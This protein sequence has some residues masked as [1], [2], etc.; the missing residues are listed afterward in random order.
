MTSQEIKTNN[1]ISLTE[2]AEKYTNYSQEYLSLRA[3]QGKL[4][5]VKIGRNWLTKKDWVEEY[6]AVFNGHGEAITHSLSD[7]KS[8]TKI[9]TNG[10]RQKKSTTEKL[11]LFSLSELE[12]YSGY[13]QE[14][15]SLRA[16]QGKL[17]AVKIG[18]NW[19][20]AKEWIDEYK[21]QVNGND[22]GL[23]IETV[24]NIWQNLASQ[25]QKISQAVSYFSQ[26]LKKQSAVLLA[27]AIL[28]FCSAGLVFGFPY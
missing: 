23:A 11:K 26:L 17:K 24:R 2:A 6:L 3:R 15:L 28:I 19:L 5:A 14:Y 7:T 22:N 1:Y 13:S 20:I 21:S 25:P 12:N 16:R 4:K 10:W 8:L 27:A 9:R 18:R